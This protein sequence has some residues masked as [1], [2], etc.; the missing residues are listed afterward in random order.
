MTEKEI[1]QFGEIET[2]WNYCP[3]YIGEW[4]EMYTT[5][6]CLAKVSDRY[7]SSQFPDALL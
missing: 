3:Y 5:D 4:I 6:S 2:A 1:L 7:S